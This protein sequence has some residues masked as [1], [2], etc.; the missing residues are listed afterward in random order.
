MKCVWLLFSVLLVVIA[1]TVEVSSA[2]QNTGESLDP[3]V[4]VIR[5]H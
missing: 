2:N 1:V 3:E 5:I 4:K